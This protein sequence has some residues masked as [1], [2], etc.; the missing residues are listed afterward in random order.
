MNKKKYIIK[1]G[2]DI[3]GYTLFESHDASMG[4]VIGRIIFQIDEKPFEFLKSLS[5]NEDVTMN[6]IDHNSQFISASFENITI[7][8]EL[9]TVIKGIGISI[10]GME[11]EYDLEVIGIPYP[12]YEEEFPHHR[13]AYDK[14][15]S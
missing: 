4:V 2:S 15:F 14:Q 11:E 7:K 6:E 10:I 9:G 1:L 8:S 3:I 5:N 12:F 13:E